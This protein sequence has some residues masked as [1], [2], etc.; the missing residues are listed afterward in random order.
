[1]KARQKNMYDDMLSEFSFKLLKHI[2]NCNS[3]QYKG[4]SRF[5]ANCEFC[6]CEKVDIKPLIFDSFS[7]Q[8]FLQK[9]KSILNFDV[10]LKHIIVGFNLKKNQKL[11]L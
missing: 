11:Y 3:S 10:C 5:D 6:L 7:V 8:K 4:K 2:L 9:L 1:M